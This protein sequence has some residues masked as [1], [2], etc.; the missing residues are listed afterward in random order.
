MSYGLGAYK[1]TSVHTSS[2]EQI[3]L[4]LYQAA[5]K[6]CKLAMQAIDEKNLAQKGEAIGKLQD[7]VIELN[8]SLDH[9]VGGKIAEELSALYDYVLHASTQ[10]NIDIEKA[11]LEG[12]LSVL[13]TLYDGWKDAIKALRKQEAEQNK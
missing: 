6:H 12:C 5:I 3:L 7:I 8:N 9:E 13:T 2:K 10:A 4:M 1:K 11:P